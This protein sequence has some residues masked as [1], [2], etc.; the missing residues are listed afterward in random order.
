MEGKFSATLKVSRVVSVYKKDDRSLVSSYRPIALIPAVA[1]VLE[2]V[3]KVQLLEYFE[4]NNLLCGA[5]HSFRRCNP[6]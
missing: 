5:Q 4:S 6:S 3:M 1:K 2:T